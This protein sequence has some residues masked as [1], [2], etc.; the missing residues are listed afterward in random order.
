MVLSDKSA[1]K[2]AIVTGGGSGIGAASARKFAEHG[3]RV[4]IM[5]INKENAEKVKEEITISMKN[6]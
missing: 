3:I 1:G 5:D 6:A 4:C 2:V